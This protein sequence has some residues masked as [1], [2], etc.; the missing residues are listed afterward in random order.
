M[1]HDFFKF[2][3]VICL[4]NSFVICPHIP[5]QEYSPVIN[6]SSVA[7][8]TSPS[9]GYL[10]NH[11][12]YDND[13]EKDNNLLSN[14]K[15]VN[16]EYLKYVLADLTNAPN[17]SVLVFRG[18]EVKKELSTAL[19]NV[20]ADILAFLGVRD[21]FNCNGCQIHYG[22][23]DAYTTI[24]KEINL[25]E[26]PPNKTLFII[27]HSLGGALATLAAYQLLKKYPDRFNISLVTF[28]AP[29]VGNQ[30]FAD[31]MNKSHLYY[32]V[33][34]I[35][36]N[37]PITSVPFDDS[38]VHAGTA[39]TFQN[40]NTYNMTKLNEDS[41]YK[42]FSNVLDVFYES[43]LDNHKEYFKLDADIIWR[44]ILSSKTAERKII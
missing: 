26:F 3:V 19:N 11:W 13:D 12:A 15:I 25:I 39:V 27:G 23:Y 29:R 17:I 5:G 22:F 38:Y 30:A 21:E 35:F 10:A 8:I 4:L 42:T 40:P 37:D 18:T 28:G 44:A 6:I 36:N 43:G 9:F 33:R 31:H 41:S 14:I 16:K 20:L 7:E 34:I 32:N 1:Y 24:L 2:F